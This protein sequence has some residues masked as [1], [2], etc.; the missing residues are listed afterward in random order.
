LKEIE[1]IAVNDG[2]TDDSLR[3]MNEYAKKDS[4]IK[5]ITHKNQGVAH[6]RNVGIKEATGEYIA[7]VDSDD[8]IERNMLQVM[9]EH[10]IKEKTDLVMCGYVREFLN[11]SKEKVFYLPTEVTYEQEE[12][13]NMLRKLVGPLEEEIGNPEGLDSLGT[14]WGKL[15]KKTLIEHIE[16][17]DLKIIGSNEDSLFNMY[18]FKNVNKII[19]LNT[20]LYHYW[21]GNTDSLTSVYKPHIQTQWK[22]LFQYIRTFITDNELDDTFHHALNNRICMCMLGVGLNECSPS[23][24][25]SLVK[26]VKNIR[27]ILHDDMIK[28]AYTTFELKH[29]PIH[30]KVF[31][32]LNK[33]RLAFPVYAMSKTINYLRMRM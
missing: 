4:R 13:T 2:S 21:K 26:K 29:L 12:V 9:Y 27:Q 24:T 25:L 23:N 14:I 33:K 30:W 15:Y 18:V 3:I 32:F 11:H 5:V 8:W 16:F 6:T 28:N 10:A 31:Y 20:P 19:F 22:Q 17:V 1:I 7:F